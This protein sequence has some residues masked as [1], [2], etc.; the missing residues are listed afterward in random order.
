MNPAN[1]QSPTSSS[2]SQAAAAHQP[3]A[4]STIANMQSADQILVQGFGNYVP[5]RPAQQLA[6]SRYPSIEWSTIVSRH[7]E[8][9]IQNLK[10]NKES[11]RKKSFQT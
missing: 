4:P 7:H 10:L 8:N 9:L 5:P 3:V 6:P 2:A 11:E 1:D